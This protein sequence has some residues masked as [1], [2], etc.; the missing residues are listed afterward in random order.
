MILLSK[1]MHPNSLKMSSNLEVNNDTIN[2]KLN[3][4]FDQKT[5]YFIISLK[6][7]AKLFKFVLFRAGKR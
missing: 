6:I 3:Y 4:F 7:L 2:T 1:P 5:A